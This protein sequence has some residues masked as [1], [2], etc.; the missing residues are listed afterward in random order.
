MSSPYE[1]IDSGVAMTVGRISS[2]AL[3]D[4]DALTYASKRHDQQLL[5]DINARLVRQTLSHL[6]IHVFPRHYPSPLLDSI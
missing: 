6:R 2:A 5:S 4:A 1:E 3:D